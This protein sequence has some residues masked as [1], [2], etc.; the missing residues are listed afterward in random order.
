MRKE[1]PNKILV[2]VG[3][4]V[5][6]NDR[7]HNLFTTIL[8]PKRSTST[9]T[10]KRRKE[11][12]KSEYKCGEVTAIELDNTGFKLELPPYDDIEKPWADNIPIII[13]HPDLPE[14]INYKIC[15]SVYR[16]WLLKVILETGNI[17]NHY[18]PGTYC[19]TND[20]QFN[21]ALLE[22]N[23]DELERQK[24]HGELLGNKE[25]YTKDYIPG[26]RYYLK[27]GV[28]NIADCIYL[29]KF[30][31]IAESGWGSYLCRNPFGQYDKYKNRC[32]N[33]H[34]F[35]PLTFKYEDEPHTELDEVV[36]FDTNNWYYDFIAFSHYSSR[37]PGI[38]LGEIDPDI[39][40]LLDP[41]NRDK[42]FSRIMAMK[43]DNNWLSMVS[44]D[45]LKAHQDE[46]INCLKS[47][48][49]PNLDAIRKNLSNT[50]LLGLEEKD[51]NYI[52]SKL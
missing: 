36:L 34:I 13:H 17:L 46:L 37:K 38:D 43:Q 8:C 48:G 30:D 35:R 14:Y 9:Q 49:S 18:L 19:L 7:R 29:G 45:Y 1:V 25:N 2:L 16:W 23:N 3:E 40:D 12:L 11:K 28:S 27:T 22:D 33:F 24:K 21:N 52:I 42:F 5:P 44:K 26:H 31:T 15:I 50:C 20:D 47:I 51:V 41:N 32:P 39:T 6:L 10:L 4:D